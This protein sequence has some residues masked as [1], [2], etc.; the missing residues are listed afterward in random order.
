MAAEGLS[1]TNQST[2]TSAA[3]PSFLTLDRI[4]DSSE[5]GEHGLGEYKWS[6][7]TA[8]YFTLEAPPAGGK[9]RDLVRN[10][11]ATGHKE[12]VVPAS[13]FV[14]EGQIEPLKV[15]SFDFSADE[16]KLLLY[17]NSKRVWRRNTRGDYW[18][19]DLASRRL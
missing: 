12:I 3:D 8:A 19:L 10:D 4:F 16:S 18:V 2:Q 7:R 15:E 17:T 6:Q 13:A 5:F 1:A 14:P 9:G 11:A